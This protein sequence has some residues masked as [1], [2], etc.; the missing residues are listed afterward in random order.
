MISDL[1][2]GPEEIPCL[3]SAK[4]PDGTSEGCEALAED[5]WEYSTTH[6][7]PEIFVNKSTAAKYLESLEGRAGVRSLHLESATIKKETLEVKFHMSCRNEK[8]LIRH[9]QHS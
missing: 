8:I 2:I 3:A 1:P 4:V 7:V 5:L 6:P 9:A